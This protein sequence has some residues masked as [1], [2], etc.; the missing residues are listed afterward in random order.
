MN[1]ANATGETTGTLP[2]LIEHLDTI[3]EDLGR[4]ERR[5][6]GSVQDLEELVFRLEGREP[7]PEADRLEPDQPMAP[8]GALPR[9]FHH[10]VG[11][12]ER[13]QGLMALAA[14]LE[15]QQQRLRAL[16]LPPNLG[17][18]GPMERPVSD[19]ERGN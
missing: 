7:E 13:I 9:A 12:Q 11:I 2:K 18:S 6:L 8:G 1:I 17:R 5:L 4:F 10:V 14:E 15:A 19:I 3:E 16:L